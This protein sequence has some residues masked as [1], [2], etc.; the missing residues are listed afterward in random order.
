MVQTEG[1][2]M[3]FHKGNL[4]S[5]KYKKI[6]CKK[7]EIQKLEDS[8]TH[9][10]DYDDCDTPVKE[11]YE[12]F[13]ANHDD[14]KSNC[15]NENGPKCCRD[16]NYYLD[17]VTGIF[18][19]S[20]LD[21]PDKNKLIN[22]FEGLWEPTL[23]EKDIYTCERHT[24]LESTRKR[25]VLHHLHDLKEDKDLIILYTEDYKKY[26]NKKWKKILDYTNEISDNLFIKI[27]NNSM[28]IVE[29]YAKFL[30][31]SDYICDTNLDELSTDDI[32]I[33]RNIDSIINSIS[34]DKISANR[35]KNIC[36]NKH[37]VDILKYKA[38]N[39]Q[40][41]NNALS[42]GIA[43]LGFFL[44]LIFL[45]DFSPLGN[46]LR[47]RSKK[48]IEVDKNMREEMPELYEKSENGKSYITYHSVSH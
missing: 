10:N 1:C 16:V 38:S 34:L 9:V 40:R 45:Y 35:D 22:Y 42:I 24:D 39:V 4:P 18:K 28:G 15:K 33:S 36:Y 8:T 25:C 31:S 19:S 20:M 47:R 27:E 5:N 14:F 46:L 30:D 37:Y 2:S 13:K 29:N 26:L 23:R 44:I 6:L 12:S 43:L 21:D 41:M 3:G 11:F 32:T 7:D 48:K 17:L